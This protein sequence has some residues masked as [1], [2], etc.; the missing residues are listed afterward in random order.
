MGHCQPGPYI[1]A[2]T[3]ATLDHVTNG[4]IGW[5]VVTGFGKSAA[6]CMGKDDVLG[7]DERYLAAQEYM[8]V[9]YQSVFH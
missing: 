3:W 9:V 5:N 1:L 7:H 6:R 8:D 2:R 4:R